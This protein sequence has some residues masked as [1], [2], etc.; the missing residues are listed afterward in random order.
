VQRRR[1]RRTRNMQSEVYPRS[2]K[3]LVPQRQRSELSTRPTRLLNLSGQRDT[4]QPLRS[5]ENKMNDRYQEQG[6]PGVKM[7]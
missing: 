6:W 5:N 1:L 3:G 4:P 2:L 7:V